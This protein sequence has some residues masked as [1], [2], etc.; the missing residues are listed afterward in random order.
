MTFSAVAA[1]SPFR[2]PLHRAF[3]GRDVRTFAVT[4]RVPAAPGLTARPPVLPLRGPAV[5]GR[6]DRPDPRSCLGLR[7]PWAG[8]PVGHRPPT[9]D[10][11]ASVHPGAPRRRSARPSGP[12]AAILPCGSRLPCDSVWVAAPRPLPGLPGPGRGGSKCF[13]HHP[14]IIL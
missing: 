1:S 7:I 3:N 14:H 8:Q 9:S 2:C 4:I 11:R 6:T 13:L 5:E 10:L 12:A